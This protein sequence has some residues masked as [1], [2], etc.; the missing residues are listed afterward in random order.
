MLNDTDPESIEKYV[1]SHIDTTISYI[2][3][4]MRRSV[5][6]MKF[7]LKILT[8]LFGDYQVP[9]SKELLQGV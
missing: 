9:C 7:S 1:S 5:R 8:L 3:A 6:A 4:N 2:S